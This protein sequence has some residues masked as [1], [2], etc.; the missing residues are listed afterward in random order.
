MKANEQKLYLIW[1]EDS[2][3]PGASYWAQFDSL[4]DAVS[5]AGD[6]CEVYVAEPKFL[7]RFKRKAEIVK[8]KK[9]K[10]RK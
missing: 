10:R 6:G 5:H 8:I 7:G 2:N 9:R 3:D 4:E 1:E